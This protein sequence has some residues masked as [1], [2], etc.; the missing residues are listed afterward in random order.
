MVASSDWRLTNQLNYLKGA[1]LV[2]RDYTT[3]SATWDHDHC[4]FC[5]SDFTEAGRGGALTVGY[6]T[7]D[8]YH[9]V[10]EPCFNDFAAMFE[11][12]VAAS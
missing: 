11:W 6:C 7:I 9:W 2:W 3:H 4:S 5:W 12:Q 10:C 1:V 8:Q